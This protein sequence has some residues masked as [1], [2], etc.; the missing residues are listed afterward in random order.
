MQKLT[1]PY[2]QRITGASPGE[3][4]KMLRHRSGL[5]QAQLA[6]HLNLKSAR[7]IRNWEGDFNLPSSD[8]LHLLIGLYLERQVFL[9][10][11]ES[12]EVRQ[13]WNCVKDW[14]ESHSFTTETYPIFDET[15]FVSFLL[16]SQ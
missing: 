15:F 1:L 5:T 13:L 6:E 14:F 12:E 8:R 16:K 3:L 10:G 2:Q 7:A 11:K 9:V 4:L